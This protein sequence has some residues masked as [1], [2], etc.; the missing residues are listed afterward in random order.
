V[1]TH[2]FIRRTGEVCQFVPLSERA[3]HAGESAHEGCDNCND[4]S[5]G[6]ELEG[7][8][9]LPYTEEQYDTLVAVTRQIQLEY[10][11]ISDGR[12]VGHAD[13]APERKTDPGS[14]FDWVRFRRMLA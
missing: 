1:S 10:P 3:W 13:V 7:T 14:S 11:A 8:D 5:I 9:D 6:I 4:Y 12:I 2:L